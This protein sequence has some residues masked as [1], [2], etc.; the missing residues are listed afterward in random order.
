MGRKLVNET[1]FDCQ[2]TPENMSLSC[3]DTAQQ[4]LMSVCPR[5]FLNSKVPEGSGKVPVVQ[6]RF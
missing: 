1:F 3:K 5:S 6:R 2:E 4:V